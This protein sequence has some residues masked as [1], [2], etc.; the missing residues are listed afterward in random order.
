MKPR[1]SEP[2]LPADLLP[3]FSGDFAGLNSEI[4]AQGSEQ[5]R[6]CEYVRDGLF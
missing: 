5:Q 2:V 4:T 6:R 1:V 3:V